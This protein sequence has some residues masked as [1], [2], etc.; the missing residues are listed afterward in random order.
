MTP[1]WFLQTDLTARL[2]LVDL[3]GPPAGL[4][5]MQ[6]RFPDSLNVGAAQY[7][8]PFTGVRP[9]DFRR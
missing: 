3:E 4:S 1:P 6:A 7:E 8:H 2:V 9:A 5:W